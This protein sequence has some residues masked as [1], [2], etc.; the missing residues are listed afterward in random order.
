MTRLLQCYNVTVTL[1]QC[2]SYT[3]TMSQLHC[4]VT[5]SQLHCHSYTVTM[6]QFHCYNVTVP[7]LQ[8]HSYTVTMSQLHC[9]NVTVTRG[10]LPR[11]R[12]NQS[13]RRESQET[14]QVGDLYTLFFS[15]TINQF[16]KTI[17]RSSPADPII[18]RLSCL[19]TTMTHVGPR[20]LIVDVSHL[21]THTTVLTTK[22]SAI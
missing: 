18:R 20:C 6:S 9:Y 11:R 21:D 1:L 14:K 7:L 13:F 19:Y 8:C 3:V 15:R 2:H 16:F 5:M 22:A 4:T 12:H 17:S 10:D